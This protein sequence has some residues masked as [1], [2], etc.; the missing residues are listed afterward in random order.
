MAITAKD[1]QALRERTSCGMMDCKKA[2]VEADGDMEKAIEILREKGLAKAAKKAGRVAAEGLAFAG[3]KG[4][5]GAIVEV[6]SETDFVAK[7]EMFKDF[8]S[9][10]VDVII[11]CNPADNA[12]LLE[13]QMDGLKVS[14]QLQELVLKIGENIQIRRFQRYEGK[15]ATY[16]HGGGT[17]A[18]I[19]KFDCEPDVTSD[20]KF[21]EAGKDVAMQIAAIAPRF[22]DRSQV[23]EEEIAKE[24]E[25]LTQQAINEGK[26]ANIAEKMVMG[27]IKKFYEENCLVDMPFVKDGSITVAK[28]LENVGKELGAKISVVAFSRY[29]RAKELKRDRTTLQQK[30]QSSHRHNLKT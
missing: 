7:N 15:L 23:S 16:I 5:A 18:V 27:R 29:E 26:P 13:C 21:V 17:H 22:V 8:V 6:N 9:K 30:L 10:L 14:E 28:Y 1:V 25:I 11:D 3:S 2:L 19:V 4:D 20:P 12:A 24:K